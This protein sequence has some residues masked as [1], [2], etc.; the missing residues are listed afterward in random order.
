MIFRFACEDPIFKVPYKGYVNFFC[1]DQPNLYVKSYN[2]TPEI[3]YENLYYVDTPE[4]YN[5]CN[6]TASHKGKRGQFSFRFMMEEN[7]PRAHVSH[8]LLF[9]NIYIIYE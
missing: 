2:D 6:A 8:I 5:S 4:E 3:I 7:T 1:V 9:R